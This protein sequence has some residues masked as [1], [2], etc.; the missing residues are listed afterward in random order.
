[1][2]VGGRWFQDGAVRHNRTRR[3]M[4]RWKREGSSKSIRFAQ[5]TGCDTWAQAT[6]SERIASRV[7]ERVLSIVSKTQSRCLTG[8]LTARQPAPLEL[9]SGQI[10][11]ITLAR[12]VFESQNNHILRFQKVT[13]CSLAADGEAAKDMRKGITRMVRN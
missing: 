8:S 13:R 1:M 11:S 5:V 9:K 10:S 4:D 6:N 7:C 12:I 3:N 2:T